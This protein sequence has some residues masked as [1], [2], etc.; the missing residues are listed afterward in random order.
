[1]KLAV[2]SNELTDS[3]PSEICSLYHLTYLYVV[4]TPTLAMLKDLICVSRDVSVNAF[5]QIPDCFENLQQLTT[6]YVTR[7]T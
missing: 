4:T 6:L 5:N 1:M 2:A 7:R 3:I